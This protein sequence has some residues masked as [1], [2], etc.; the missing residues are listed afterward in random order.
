MYDFHSHSYPGESF[1]SILKALRSN[2]DL[3][4][5]TFNGHPAT[6]ITSHRALKAAFEDN[7]LFPGHLSYQM[8]IEQS[9]G[10]SFISMPDPEPHRTYRK[11]STPAFKSRNIAV[12]DDEI[13][14]HTA[15]NLIDALVEK[16]EI[17]LVK[18]FTARFPYLV[19]TQLLGI[20][21]D[22][23]EEF[24]EWA[25]ALLLPEENEH[26]EK[27]QSAFYNVLRPIIAARRK[28]PKED[29]ISELTSVEID[30]IELND[31]EIL[32]HI[33][34]L[35]PTGGETTHGS[36]GNLLY[37]LLTHPSLWQRLRAEPH[38]IPSAVDELSR[39]ESSVAL[40]PRISADKSF[41]FFDFNVPPNS[42]ILFGIAAANRDPTVFNNP[43][44]FNI[45][46]E[47]KDTLAFGRGPKTCPGKHLAK[48]NM[49]VA[50]QLLLER[51]PN[52]KLT[53]IEDSQPRG[54]ALRSP[55]AL[56]VTQV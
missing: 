16:K 35:F 56:N 4:E 13:F 41:N 19:I 6:V 52:L 39:W 15:N 36:L 29:I 12:Y 28:S 7:H 30:G 21:K 8:S 37:A 51:L 10:K 22:K 18:D 23:E 26:S 24:H 5:V 3:S 38:L 50:I 17:D 47:S 49:I 44:E 55:L 46:R 48:R 42:L 9:I 33:G 34:L 54:S 53:N 1:H 2:G 31:D 14:F 45:E 43:D 27:K 11:L 20:P 25:M 32:N 40:L